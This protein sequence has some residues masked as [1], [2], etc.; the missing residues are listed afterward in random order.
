M[1]AAYPDESFVGF[2]VEVQIELV[3][4]KTE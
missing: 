2:S 3:A 4:T 1:G